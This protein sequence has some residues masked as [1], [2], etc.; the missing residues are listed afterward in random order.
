MALLE[1]ITG[2]IV[3][4]LL[5]ECVKHLVECVKKD[6]SIEAPQGFPQEGWE[7]LTSEGKS[8][9]ETCHRC[10]LTRIK[11]WISD[12]FCPHEKGAIL[13]L[14]ERI[15]FFGAMWVGKHEVIAGWLAFK[16]ASKW[17]IFNYIIK[18][19]DELEGVSKIS[20]LV[21]R[22]KLG[23]LRMMT[24]LIGTLANVVAAGC[25][26]LVGKNAWDVVQCLLCL[27]S[28]ECYYSWYFLTC[29]WR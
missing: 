4:I 19:P 26:L 18:F 3:T 21:A 11:K 10:L 16:V 25:G 22:R 5:G 17:A 29:V 27:L 6:N 1:A 14:L 12:A 28:H 7:Q 20:Y 9:T 2:L 23:S 8:K 15:V 13:G 24:F